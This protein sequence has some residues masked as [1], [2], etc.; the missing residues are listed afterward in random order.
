MDKVKCDKC[1]SDNFPNSKY[2]MS[3]GYEMPKREPEP[4]QEQYIEVVR[5]PKIK[6]KKSVRGVIIGFVVMAII[7]YGV[8]YYLTSNS[9][10]K[11]LGLIASEWN[12]NLPMMVDAAT[13]LDNMMVL[14][15]K[16]LQYTYT[17]SVLLED[18]TI[19]TAELKKPIMENCINNART[20]PDMDYMREHKVTMKYYY[21]DL[22]G[23]YIFSFYVKPEDY[24]TK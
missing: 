19:D 24:I 15:Q 4:E 11:Q 22:Q 18:I 14:P 7:S 16:T 12:K 6:L 1:G 10:D 3:C 5:Y 21:K 17:V 20:N 23:R 2:C 8:Q 9:I 13:R